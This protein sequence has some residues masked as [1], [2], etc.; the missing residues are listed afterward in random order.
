ARHL[1]LHAAVKGGF[2]DVIMLQ[3]NP[4]IAQEDNMNRAL[5]ACHKQGIGLISMKQVAGNWNLD[6][7]GMNL[8]ELTEKGLTP[9][10]ALLHAIWTDERFSSVCVS[11][12]NTD[13]IR[14]NAA[15]ARTFQPVKKTEI[16]PLRGASIAAGAA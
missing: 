1:L 13:Q 14:E 15:A 7:I 5:D 9:Y 8:P 6:E 2:V 16:D 11:M 4:W 10:Q 12:R 3:N